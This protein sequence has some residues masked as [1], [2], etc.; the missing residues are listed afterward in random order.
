L[1]GLQRK[2]LSYDVIHEALV[3]GFEVSWLH[4]ACNNLCGDLR[5]CSFNASR[6]LVRQCSQPLCTGFA[7]YGTSDCGNAKSKHHYN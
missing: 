5:T 2:Q 3:Y 6:D 4:L 1:S 7:G